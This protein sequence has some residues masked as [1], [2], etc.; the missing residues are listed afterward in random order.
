MKINKFDK[1]ILDGAMDNRIESI[2][3]VIDD[4]IN[5]IRKSIEDE[6]IGDGYTF[7]FTDLFHKEDWK[8]LSDEFG[9]WHFGRIFSSRIN[10]GNYPIE[11][12][13]ENKKGYANYRILIS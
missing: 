6:N 3:M 12:I 1:T 5:M 2:N 8:Y 9:N 10:T 7:I 4:R 13:G 11:R